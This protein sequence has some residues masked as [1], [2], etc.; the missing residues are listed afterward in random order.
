[1]FRNTLKL[2]AAGLSLIGILLTVVPARAQEPPSDDA[3]LDLAEP[4]FAIVNLPTTLRLPARGGNFH[5]SHRFNENLRNDSFADQASSLFGLDEGANIALEFR[6]GVVRHLQAIV[7]RT[8]VSR[9]I[10]FSAKYDAWH[11]R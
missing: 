1:M 4:D 3:T 2:R 8:S 9:T 6:Y 7:Q 10:Q 5:L 11:Q